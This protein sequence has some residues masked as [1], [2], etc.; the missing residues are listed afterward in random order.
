MALLAVLN[1][2]DPSWNGNY[3]Q[4]EF[5]SYNERYEGSYPNLY[6][7]FDVQARIV[8]I[9]SGWWM[10]QANT[11][12]NYGGV[13]Q[14]HYI[15]TGRVYGTSGWYFVGS[16]RKSCGC[17]RSFTFDDGCSVSGYPNLSGNGS[18]TSPTIEEPSFTA[19]AENID[20]RTCDIV[21]DT[22]DNPYN[23][24]RMYVK[25]PNGTY[26]SQLPMDGSY[27]LEGLNSNTSYTYRVEAW[28]AD[29]RGSEVAGKDVSFKTL[30]NYPE[31]S[32]TEVTYEIED[33][34]ETDN[35]TFRFKSTDDSH[36]SK[37]HY[38]IQGGPPFS[39]ISPA[40]SARPLAKNLESYIDVWTED[41]LGRTS[42]KFRQYFHT[43]FTKMTVWR[44]MKTNGYQLF[45]AS[46]LATTEA[47]DGIT[48]TNNNDGSFILNG[49]SKNVILFST[50]LD[51][52][53]EKGKK[54]TIS[55][56]NDSVHGG[57]LMRLGYTHVDV[58]SQVLMN[59]KNATVTFTTTR[60][61]NEFVIR[62][63]SGVTLNNFKI[64]PMLN[65]EEAKAWE[66][67]TNGK[68]FDGYLRGFMYCIQNMLWGY[69]RPYVLN[70]GRKWLNALPY[71]IVRRF[72]FSGKTN[73]AGLEIHKIYG[74][75]VQETTK[76]YQLFDASKIPTIANSGATVTNN[77]DGSFTISGRGT[78]TNVYANV[79]SNVKDELSKVL[80]PGRISITSATSIYPYAY[81]LFEFQ[82]G[83]SMEIR[84]SDT[85]TKEITQEDINN[86]KSIYYGF[87]GAKGMQI[88]TGTIKVMVFQD[89][90]GTWEAYT[91]GKPGPNADGPLPIRNFEISNIYSC[92]SNILENTSQTST[93]NGITFTVNKDGSVNVNGTATTQAEKTLGY[94]QLLANVKY[95][96]K[97]SNLK[98]NSLIIYFKFD[99]NKYVIAGETSDEITFTL[100][101]DLYAKIVLAVRI[102]SSLNN[103]IAYPQINMGNKALPYE[104]FKGSTTKS[105]VTLAKE[106]IYTK[107]TIL[108]KRKKIVFDG[109][110][111]EKWIYDSEAYRF[112]ITVSDSLLY[113]NKRIPV[114]CNRGVFKESGIDPGTTFIGANHL[115]YYSLDRVIT[116]VQDFKTWLSTHPL[117]VEY[118][119]QTPTT[120]YVT[121]PT[122]T[123]FDPYTNAWTDSEV[124]TQIEWRPAASSTLS[125]RFYAVEQY[126]KVLNEN[127]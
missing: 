1:H 38:Q 76:G 36:V 106:D 51:K 125:E 121:I 89:G 110:E 85:H 80:K 114:V 56:N 39:V 19:R 60:E 27:S 21:W 122:I 123:S 62:I 83:R 78:L 35:V 55:A 96:M 65:K 41:T 87:Y 14:T 81:F 93:I 53:V 15:Y 30:E 88:K 67:Y 3:A 24:Y 118:P 127:T 9:N 79:S 31:I 84:S 49:T 100:D 57:V 111:D 116:K 75:T 64:K 37:W 4:I 102:N 66:P 44:R 101:S 105:S 12:F 124:E 46:K 108:R 48:I 115:Y 6:F 25:A 86:L 104:P 72:I 16:H 74:N 73:A 26:S 112:A 17:G 29:G 43:T 42:S 58:A 109:S 33:A 61:S 90:D 77:N 82:D 71:D 7:C 69:A 117:E 103:V 8:A 97:C 68:P 28:Q 98:N 91:A 47:V 18:I 52:I 54:Y 63:A 32:V 99:G 11:T 95:T 113:T 22:T 34:G 23:M 70:A 5:H 50:L 119:L 94:V 13:Q 120:E 10:I 45:D 59:S 40:Y 126:R 2:G 20:Q 92:S 107:S